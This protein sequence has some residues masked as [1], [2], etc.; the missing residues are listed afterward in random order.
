[1][2]INLQAF[3]KGQS[4]KAAARAFLSVVD[5]MGVESDERADGRTGEVVVVVV[6]RW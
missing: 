1:M 2:Q 5:T 3:L 4:S 6:C